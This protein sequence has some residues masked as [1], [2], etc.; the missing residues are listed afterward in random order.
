[1][2]PS[3]L[4]VEKDLMSTLEFID[5]YKLGNITYGAKIEFAGEAADTCRIEDMNVELSRNEYGAIE[6]DKV[7]I[8]LYTESAITSIENAA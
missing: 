6:T 1:M 7:E 5:K 2:T 3:A 4:K 8:T